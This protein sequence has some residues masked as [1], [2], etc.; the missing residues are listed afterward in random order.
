MHIWVV[1][2]FWLLNDRFWNEYKPQ[3]QVY[4]SLNYRPKDD[5]IQRNQL[6]LD[7]VWKRLNTGTSQCGNASKTGF[8]EFPVLFWE[9]PQNWQMLRDFR[10]FLRC[11]LIFKVEVFPL[12]F[13]C[14]S[15][16]FLRRFR[17]LK[18][19]LKL[20]F[21]EAFPLFFETFPFFFWGISVFWKNF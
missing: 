10:K 17:F 18:K 15:V 12:F 20:Y 14:V 6:Q 2:R 1:N 7:L 3:L 9:I 19:L 4:G 13:W 21:V 11:F 5:L 8:E 16:F